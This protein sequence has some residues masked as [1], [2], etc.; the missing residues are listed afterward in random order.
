MDNIGF[1]V[2]VNC[3]TY[4]HSAYIEVAMDGFCMQETT[5]PYICTIT[6]DASTD[7]TPDVIKA[8][9][10]EHFVLDDNTLFEQRETS[11]YS[12]IFAKH[13]VNKNCFFAV[14]FLKYNHYQIGKAKSY[15]REWNKMVKYMAPCEG[16]DYWIDNNKLQIQFDYLERNPD[17]GLVRMD[18]DKLNV[19]T[20]LVVKSL[21]S[22][23]SFCK[24]QDTHVD[25]LLHGWF[26][27]PCTWMYRLC[28]KELCPKLDPVVY[29]TGDLNIVLSISRSH[30]VHFIPQVVAV[31]RESEESAS[32][33][34]NYKDLFEFKQKMKNTRIYYAKEQSFLVRM[35]CWWM[36]CIARIPP[37]KQ[38]MYIPK[39]IGVCIETFFKLL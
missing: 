27:A 23:T 24:I 19:K 15:S 10:E 31:Y 28:L 34:K 18:V 8:Y 6:D 25:Y 32:H 36:I 37:I 9:L 39:W 12:L 33:F 30:R 29:F 1:L 4:N 13:K 21:F 38:W 11:D 3:N 16:D 20:G 14:Y 5:F 17:C 7:G 26:L 22:N 2:R 35:R